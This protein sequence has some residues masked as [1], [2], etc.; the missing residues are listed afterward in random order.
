M[1][2]TSGPRTDW[3]NGGEAEMGETGLDKVKT[4]LRV[5][6]G[7]F[8]EMY[9]FFLFGIYARQIAAH[10]LSERR[11]LRLA[12][13]DLP[14]FR[15]GVCDAPDRRAGAGA[16]HRPHRPPQRPYSDAL[17][18][19]LRHHPDRLRAGLRD[20][21]RA[22]AHAGG[23]GTAPSGILGRRRARRRLGLSV[24]DGDARKQGLLRRLAIGEPAGRG[25]TRRAAW[26]RDRQPDGAGSGRRAG[27]GAFRSSSAARSCR[28]C[29]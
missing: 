19:G 4:V 26:L 22:R 10:L 15:G 12:D 16:V 20:H 3:A 6:G 17:D 1:C 25:R 14:E 2:R 8:L 28:S 29:T 27:A 9:D 21:R 7:N 5:T 18:H 11:P 24:G 13:G 23:A